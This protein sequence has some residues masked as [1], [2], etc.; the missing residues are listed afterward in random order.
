MKVAMSTLGEKNSYCY[1]LL[2]DLG[3]LCFKTCPLRLTICCYWT[4]SK[5]PVPEHDCQETCGKTVLAVW[6][7]SSLLW[8]H[9]A[10]CSASERWQTVLLGLV[11][12]QWQGI[13]QHRELQ[14][15]YRSCVWGCDSQEVFMK[16]LLMGP[17]FIREPSVKC[18]LFLLCPCNV[19]FA[20]EKDWYLMSI[21]FM[22]HNLRVFW[23]LLPS[24]INEN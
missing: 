10:W 16:V 24:P 1:V 18:Y 11:S 6:T 21:C 13:C 23:R 3:E 12:S 7:S 8:P 9:A 14:R 4:C 19:N 2:R 22:F 17:L 15:P 20:W 5:P